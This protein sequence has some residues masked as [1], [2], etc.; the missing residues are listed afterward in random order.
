MKPKYFSDDPIDLTSW[1][2]LWAMAVIM[3]VGLM[4]L[5]G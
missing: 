3:V 5:E 1:L 4:V 2:I